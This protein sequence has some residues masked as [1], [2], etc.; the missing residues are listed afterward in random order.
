MSNGVKNKILL[1]SP[2]GEFKPVLPLGLA[3]IAAYLKDKN[4]DVEI[5]IID[6]WAENLEFKELENRVSQTQADIIGVYMVSPFYDKGKSTIEVCRKALPNSLIIA[7]GPHPSALPAETLKDIPQLDICA[8]GEGEITMHELVG[9]APLSTIDGIVYREGQEIKTNK[10]REFIKNLDE[11]PLPARELFP[12]SKYKTHPPY[13]RKN[14]YF[15]IITSRGCPY[16]CAFCSKDVFKYNYR[17]FSP[18]RVCDELE[19]LISKY[20]AREVHFYDDDFTLDM[21]R[22]EEICDEILKRG[23]KILWSCTTRVDLVNENLLRKMKQAGCWLISYG[24][25]SGNQKIL[26]A[27]NKGFTVEQTISAFKITKKVG[28]LT[29]GF[30]M[31]GLPSE[32]KK[33]IQNTLDL[34]KKIRPDFV[35]WGILIAYPGSHLFKLTQAGKYPGRLRT[36]NNGENLAGTYFGKGNYT[37]FEDNLTFEELRTIVKKANRAFYLRPQ[38][39]LQTLTRIRS[40]SDLSYYLKGGIEVIRS[41]ME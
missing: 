21:Q 4:K 23:I 8:I 27:I 6:A 5:T 7:G 10:L 30:F 38:Y 9:S 28:L 41:A 15:S 1:V 3:S 17:A 24:V 33:T 2:P 26:D 36:L 11:L 14:P 25:E 37:V 35:S 16:Q 22:A 32:T 31:V 19:E 20:G 34:A 12:I 29:L 18:K 13:G 39:I 40:F